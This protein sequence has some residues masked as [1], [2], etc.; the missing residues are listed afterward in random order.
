MFAVFFSIIV[1]AA[2]LSIL[3]E[4]VM[5]VRI[6]RMEA[7]R[8]RLT[9]WRRGGDEVAATYGELFPRS[10]LPFFRRVVFWLIVACAGALL[11]SIGLLKSN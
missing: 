10:P 8:D 9:W 11:V 6:T 2:L 5:R 4:I 7:A 3:S 1:I